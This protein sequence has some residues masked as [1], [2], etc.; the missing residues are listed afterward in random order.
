MCP[1]SLKGIGTGSDAE[2]EVISEWFSPADSFYTVWKTK[3]CFARDQYLPL[4]L[5]TQ[6]GNND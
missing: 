2:K 5:V 3:I 6:Y 1:V 4:T